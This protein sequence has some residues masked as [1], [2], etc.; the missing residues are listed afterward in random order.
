MDE[1]LKVKILPQDG[2]VLGCLLFRG[3]LGDE[4]FELADLELEI[5]LF[6][7]QNLHALHIEFHFLGDG[8]LVAHLLHV[9]IDVYPLHAA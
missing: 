6:S 7:T 9:L 5:E 3:G 2:L 4:F 8:L 1:G